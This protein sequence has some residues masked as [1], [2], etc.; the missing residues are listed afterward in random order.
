MRPA[1]RR[2]ARMRRRRRCAVILGVRNGISP[3]RHRG[4]RGV[5]VI[6]PCQA[7][8]AIVA[9]WRSLAIATLFLS[10]H[11][12]RG[13]SIWVLVP[14]GLPDTGKRTRA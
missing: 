5:P 12:R 8:A 9:S 7:A 13:A 1:D 14:H 6:E 2:R 4:R 10:L 3:R 11:S